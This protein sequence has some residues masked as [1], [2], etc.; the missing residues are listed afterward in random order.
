MVLSYYS[1]WIKW[2]RGK[3]SM[4]QC[5][6]CGNICNNASIFCESCQTA[7]LSRAERRSF[8]TVLMPSLETKFYPAAKIIQDDDIDSRPLAMRPLPWVQRQA[9]LRRKRRLLIVIALFVIIALIIDGILVTLVFMHPS[10]RK[11]R[12]DTFPSPDV[13][14]QGQVVRVCLD[15]YLPLSLSFGTNSAELI[16]Q[17]KV[18]NAPPGCIGRGPLEA[19]TWQYW[20]E[21]ENV[22]AR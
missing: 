17:A 5:L 9:E 16:D 10:S 19:C 14:Y 20:R 12:A 2:Q 3:S 21:G 8:Q 18:S 4:K 7:L 13:V 11:L 22:C 6:Q 1:R 15:Y